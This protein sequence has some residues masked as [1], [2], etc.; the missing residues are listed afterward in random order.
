MNAIDGTERNELLRKV[1][2]RVNVS[3]GSLPDLYNQ[4]ISREALLDK[5]VCDSLLSMRSALKSHYHSDM[6]SCLHANSAQKQRFPAVNMVRQL[7][8]TNG[9]YMQPRIQSMG[10]DRNTGKKLVKRFYVILPITAGSGDD[11]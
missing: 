9:M 2:S 3:F 5:K 7:L 8:R 1:L 4:V 11:A 6:L 10:Y